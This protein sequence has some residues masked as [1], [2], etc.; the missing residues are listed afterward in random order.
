[1]KVAFTVFVF[2]SVT[3]ASSMVID[4]AVE[5]FPAD[6]RNLPQAEGWVFRLQCYDRPPDPD[7]EPPPILSRLSLHG[8]ETAHPGGGESGGLAP[9]GAFRHAS[10]LGTVAGWLAKE[11]DR[12]QEFVGF[13]RRRRDEETQ[14]VPVSGRLAR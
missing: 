11:D 8:K 6:R 7:R 9:Q 10:L 4:G 3:V 12:P 5:A 14:L 13:L 2:P 1:M